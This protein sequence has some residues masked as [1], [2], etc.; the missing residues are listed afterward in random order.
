MAQ[1]AVES[2]A[3][4]QEAGESGKLGWCEEGPVGRTVVGK[5]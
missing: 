2:R 1:L 5:K 3:G 4:P